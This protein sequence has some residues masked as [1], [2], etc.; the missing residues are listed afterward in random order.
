MSEE[1]VGSG[2]MAHLHMAFARKSNP[3]SLTMLFETEMAHGESL[4]PSI[5]GF[6]EGFEEGRGLFVVRCSFIAL[7]K[8]SY[9]GVDA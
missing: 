5:P 7:L 9:R 8:R 3:L 6:S 1:R 2:G 4:G